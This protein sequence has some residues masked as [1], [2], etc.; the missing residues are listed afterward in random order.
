MWR[1]YRSGARL[2]RDPDR[3]PE[4]KKAARKAPLLIYL[5]LP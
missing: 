3:A 2:H 5:S 4:K 1:E